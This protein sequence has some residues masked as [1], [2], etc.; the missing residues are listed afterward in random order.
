[1][2]LPHK[3]L[4]IITQMWNGKLIYCTITAATLLYNNAIFYCT[5]KMLHTACPIFIYGRQHTQQLINSYKWTYKGQQ[6]WQGQ[7]W[8]LF[9]WDTVT[10]NSIFPA[11]EPPSNSNTSEIEKSS[12]TDIQELW[13]GVQVTI[14]L[15]GNGWNEIS[16]GLAADR[17][18]YSCPN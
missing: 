6:P 15:D 2:I 3:V 7:Y 4:K 17:N 13:G 8:L 5:M 12:N 1:M 14:H 11:D 9:Y 16:I 18:S 10:T